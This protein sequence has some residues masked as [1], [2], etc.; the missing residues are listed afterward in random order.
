MHQALGADD[1]A[2]E[3]LADRL[4]AEAH[5][6]DRQIGR[7][8]RDQLQADAGLIRRAGTGREQHRFGLE[9]EGLGG[10]ERIVADHARLGPQLVQIVDEVVGEAVIIIDDE[11]HGAPSRPMERTRR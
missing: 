4:V 11:D 9:G 2:A 7:G 8:G 5:A 1:V 6:Q 3:G 10:G